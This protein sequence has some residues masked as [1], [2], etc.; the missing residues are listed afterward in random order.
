MFDGQFDDF[1]DLFDLFV[2]TADHLVCRVG[3][4][5]NHHQ[6]DEGVDFVG[7]YFV[8]GVRVVTEGNSEWMRGR[9]RK[10]RKEN[11]NGGYDFMQ[12]VRIVR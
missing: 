1:F 7:Q 9:K 2:E 6:R 8:E 11:D 3:N 10:R 12:G 4:F 5:L